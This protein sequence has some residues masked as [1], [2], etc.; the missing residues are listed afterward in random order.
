MTLTAI[1]STTRAIALADIRPNPFRQI[2]KY[3]IARAKIAALRESIDRTGFWEN[4]VVRDAPDGPEIAYGHHRLVALREHYGEEAVFRFIVRPL[5]DDAMYDVMVREN[6]VEWSTNAALDQET[7]RAL[8]VG[9]AEGRLHLDPPNGKTSHDRI[10]YAP[11]ALE[12]DGPAPL[13]DHPYTADAIAARIGWALDRVRY[14]LG[15]LAAIEE[16]GLREDTFRSLT[17]TQAREVIVAQRKVEASHQRANTDP[18][19]AR[20]ARRRTI[21]EGI[22]AYQQDKGRDR[23][24]AIAEEHAP[25]AKSKPRIPSDRIVQSVEDR[26]RGLLN[27]RVIP[28]EPQTIAELLDFVADLDPAPLWPLTGLPFAQTLAD[29]LDGLAHEATSHARRLRGQS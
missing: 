8:L 27:G 9:Y 20:E 16:L 7:I 14:T 21:R 18:G 11:S 3:P 29:A 10:R 22:E 5:D 12:G 2:D 28:A 4:V 6:A 24:Q 17:S 19:V 1:G 13:R 25:V 23:V 26:I 15:A